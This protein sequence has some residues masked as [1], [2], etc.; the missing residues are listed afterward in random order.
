MQEIGRITL[1]Q[2]QR[3]KLVIEDQQQASYYDPTPLLAVESLQLMPEGVIGRTAD[4][5]RVMDVHHTHHPDSQNLKGLNGVS[6]GFTS[7]Y[8]SMRQAFGNHLVD[9]SAGENIIVEA[10]TIL[11][12]GDLGERLVI[13]TQS[14]G[15]KIYLTRLKVAT[16][17]V[18][19]SQFAAN[20][21]MPMA[22]EQLKATLQYLN[23]GRRGFY[24][25]VAASNEEI[26]IGIGDRV[27]ADESDV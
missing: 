1:L 17:C 18:E 3:S 21:G 19:F 11:T 4:G 25:T 6:L 12:L 22:A 8:R 23:E 9:G 27:F 14:T 16:P 2:V 15:Q 24:A 26:N 7:H 13:Q 5:S 20:G 10:E